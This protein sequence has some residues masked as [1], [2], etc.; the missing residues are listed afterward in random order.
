MVG[1]QTMTS[2]QAEAFERLLDV[3]AEEL[4]ERYFDEIETVGGNDQDRCVQ[5]GTA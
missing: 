1:S 5:E 4:V 3:I 2:R